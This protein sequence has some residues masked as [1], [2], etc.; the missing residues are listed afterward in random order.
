MDPTRTERGKSPPH[1]IQLAVAVVLTA[2]AAAMV[3]AHSP[4]APPRSQALITSLAAPGQLYAGER[5][6]IYGSVWL[7]EERTLD[8]RLRSCDVETG[9]CTTSGW[10]TVRGPGTWMGFAGNFTP[11]RPGTWV[12]S[13]TLYDT[14]LVDAR[15]AVVRYETEVTVVAAPR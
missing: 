13:W 14:W 7:P 12:L 5:V 4:P 6:S 10:G 3:L 8:R 9:E 2:L 11:E 1:S 15:R